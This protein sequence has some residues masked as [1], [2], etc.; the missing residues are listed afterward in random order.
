M[1]SVQA[2]ICTW[3]LPGT[4]WD[5]KLRDSIRLQILLESK[6]YRIRCF[7]YLYLESNV[8]I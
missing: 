5:C 6:F 4:K 8:R 2:K 3:D 1:C 7:M